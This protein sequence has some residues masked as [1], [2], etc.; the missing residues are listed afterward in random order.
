MRQENTWRF[1]EEGGG[2]EKPSDSVE[3]IQ[4]IQADLEELG[5]PRTVETP[6]S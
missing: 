4:R 2:R 3:R 1:R 5:E 6:D